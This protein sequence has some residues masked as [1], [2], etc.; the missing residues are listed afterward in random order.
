MVGTFD[1]IGELAW[2]ASVLKFSPDHL[3]Q[4]QNLQRFFALVVN[5]PRLRPLLRHIIRWRPNGLFWLVNKLWKGYV[6]K[7][8]VHPVKLSLREYVDLIWQ[9]MRIN[10]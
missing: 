8:R 1:D 3:R 6:I 9:F 10:S 4:L 2:D 7:T 5:W